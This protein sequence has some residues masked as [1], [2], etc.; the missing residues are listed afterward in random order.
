MLG[1]GKTLATFLSVSWLF[2]LSSPCWLQVVSPGLAALRG[3]GKLKQG[4]KSCE[5][6]D[7]ELVVVWNETEMVNRE[8]KA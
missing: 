1:M 7:P 5:D 4:K 2:L 3:T 8:E 6:W